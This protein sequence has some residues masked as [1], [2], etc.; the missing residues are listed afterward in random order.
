VSISALHRTFSWPIWIQFTSSN[1]ISLRSILILSYNLCLDLCK[2]EA[3]CSPN[4]WYLP[5]SP[6]G[7]TTQKTNINIFT[8]VRTSN[9]TGFTAYET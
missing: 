9:L 3:V 5:A 4:H 1:P 7:I 2:M 6:H 8:V